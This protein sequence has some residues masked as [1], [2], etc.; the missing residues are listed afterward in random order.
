MRMDV[1]VKQELLQMFKQRMPSEEEGG[2]GQ[3]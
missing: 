3:R 1:C 2:E